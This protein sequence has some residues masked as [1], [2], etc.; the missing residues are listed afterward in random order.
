MPEHKGDGSAALQ[1]L[2]TYIT[3]KAWDHFVE[4][5]MSGD[6]VQG[7]CALQLSCNEQP[8]PLLAFFSK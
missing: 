7:T 3:G 8:I 2:G 4:E 5:M 6:M 1:G